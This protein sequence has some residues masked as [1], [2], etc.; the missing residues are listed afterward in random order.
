[1]AGRVASNPIRALIWLAVGLLGLTLV[2]VGF[3]Y[4]ITRDSAVGYRII[5]AS[6]SWFRTT[7]D[8]NYPPEPPA[9][10]DQDNLF[11]ELVRIG[12][13]IPRARL[14][15]I[16]EVRFSNDPE[17]K[18]PSH[19]SWVRSYLDRCGDAPTELRAAAK[20]FHQYRFNDEQEDSR[21]NLRSLEWAF[22][23]LQ[24]D[25]QHE[26]SDGKLND[27][28]N[29]LFTTLRLANTITAGS[30]TATDHYTAVDAAREARGTLVT[31]ISKLNRA[32]TQQAFDLIAASPEKD[33][34]LQRALSYGSRVML[35]YLHRE[36]TLD[37]L[38]SYGKGDPLI[39]FDDQRCGTLDEQQTITE[40]IQLMKVYTGNCELPWNRLDQAAEKTLHDIRQQLPERP[41][42]TRLTSL[43]DDL[44]EAGEYRKKMNK[45]PNSRG[46]LFLSMYADYTW[47]ISHSFY[48]RTGAN[49][50]RIR[51]ATRLYQ[52]DHQGK[53]PE[54][55][56][57]LV[58][59]KYLEAL[60]LD[61]F[62]GRPFRYDAKRKV[63]WSAGPD[64]VD[65]GGVETANDA[66]AKGS[67]WVYQL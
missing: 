41:S 23:V 40:W 29:D 33:V 51:L 27:G 39:L 30:P 42:V 8:A 17:L 34:E 49:S 53:F 10:P 5:P 2:A 58:K 15:R 12:S 32:Q 65:N 11:V 56:E 1:M 48:R 28:L 55:L 57:E 26:L 6:E 38:R 62:S 60:P 59:A 66:S 16:Q 64:G 36:K 9:I 18:D 20:T 25:S 19:K 45:L 21:R 3:V 43:S 47:P 22:Y 13:D 46:K 54:S 52:F 67:D 61:L 35:E 37:W 7:L 31:I 44:W 14:S 63:I 4:A 24:L 50:T